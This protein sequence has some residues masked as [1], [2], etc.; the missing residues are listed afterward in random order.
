MM[1]GEGA[2]TLEKGDTLVSGGPHVETTWDRYAGTE[3]GYSQVGRWSRAEAQRAVLAYR[4]GGGISL[5]VETGGV[6][7]G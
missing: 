7:G 4:A 1:E 6:V 5:T 2:A 3:T